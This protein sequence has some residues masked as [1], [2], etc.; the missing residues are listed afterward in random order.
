[1]MANKQAGTCE[2]HET[3]QDAGVNVPHSLTGT[4]IDML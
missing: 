1:M 2:G 3:K 4:Y